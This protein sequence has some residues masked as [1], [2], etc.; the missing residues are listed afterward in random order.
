LSFPTMDFW[1]LVLQFRGEGNCVNHNFPRPAHKG[2]GLNR[3]RVR[4]CLNRLNLLRRVVRFPSG[5]GLPCHPN[6]ATGHC[7]NNKLFPLHFH[8]SLLNKDSSILDPDMPNQQST[9][10]H[11]VV[12]DQPSTKLD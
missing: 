9:A 7:Q 5:A 2:R 4:P 6:Q 8:F 1:C 10:R 3:K 11:D 12:Q